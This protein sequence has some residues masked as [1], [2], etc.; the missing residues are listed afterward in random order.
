MVLLVHHTI[1]IT[2]INDKVLSSLDA[3]DK[4][5]GE[6]VYT[7]VIN[8]KC[9]T[10]KFTTFIV[11]GIF[12]G[13]AIIGILAIGGAFVTYK[14]REEYYQEISVKESES[15]MKVMGKSHI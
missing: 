3:S 9:D 11:Y 10:M 12:A 15:E 4:M 2:N 1:D 5:Y 14:K 13:L 8:E 6:F 7:R